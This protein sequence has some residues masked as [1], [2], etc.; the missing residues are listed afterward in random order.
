MDV[1]TDLSLVKLF[2]QKVFVGMRVVVAVVTDPAKNRGQL[3]VSRAVIEASIA[4]GAS[5]V[6]I[7]S[8][9]TACS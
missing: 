3:V 9:G 4:S 5:A 1:S 2:K 6:D 7:A 8:T